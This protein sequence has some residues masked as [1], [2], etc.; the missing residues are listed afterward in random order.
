MPIFP[1]PDRGNTDGCS[2]P[3]NPLAGRIQQY[4]ERMMRSKTEI[5]DEASRKRGPPES[6]E[7]PAKRQKLGAEAKA[8]L[9]A[10]R[11]E[12]PP[13]TPGPHTIADL[14]TISTDEALKGFDVALLP[15]DLVVKIGVTI[16]Q[17]IDAATIEQA[18]NV[19]RSQD[20]VA[21]YTDVVFRACEPD[22]LLLRL[23]SRKK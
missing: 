22:I 19:S 7:D 9:P 16:L 5:F 15:E 6:V 17:R 18:I 20:D 23:P 8:A 14:F 13:L 11:L 21:I 1:V 12:V 3:Q 10:V 4:V 2:D